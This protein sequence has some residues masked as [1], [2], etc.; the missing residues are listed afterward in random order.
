MT[1]DL[2]GRV[3]KRYD[4]MRSERDR[5]LSEWDLCDIQFEA[6]TFEDQNGKLYVN[7][8]IEQNLIEMELGRTA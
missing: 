4:E 8:P 5:F 3:I 6:E 2:L 1:K 7:N